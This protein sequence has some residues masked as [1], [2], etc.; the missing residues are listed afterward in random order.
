MC[1][2]S[3]SKSSAL[4]L[5]RAHVWRGLLILLLLLRRLDLQRLLLLLQLG[6]QEDQSS[7]VG[8]LQGAQQH[9]ICIIIIV[10]SIIIL[11]VGCA[12]EKRVYLFIKADTVMQA[13]V[14]ARRG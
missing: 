12:R 13:C 5:G 3:L 4:I 7:L 1:E 6:L 10:M 9:G 2:N 8:A 14:Y 11:E